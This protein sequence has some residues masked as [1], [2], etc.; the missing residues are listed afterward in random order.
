M[1][2]MVNHLVIGFGAVVCGLLLSGLAY[3][4]TLVRERWARI[5]LKEMENLCELVLR[6]ERRVAVGERAY[7]SIR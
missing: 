1:G 3:V 5:D 6:A 7:E 2:G 4:V